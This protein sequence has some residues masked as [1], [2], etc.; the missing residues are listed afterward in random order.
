MKISETDP[1][2]KLVAAMK[3]SFDF[4]ATVLEKVDDS[5][6]GDQFMMFGNRPMSRGRSTGGIGRK[7]DGPLCNGGDLFAAKWDF[8]ADGAAGEEIAGLR[9]R[10]KAGPT[11][12]V[13]A[14]QSRGRHDVSCPYKIT[15]TA[16]LKAA[17][18]KVIPAG[19]RLRARPFRRAPD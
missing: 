17:A 6:L 9:G 10:R 15:K 16:G 8:A 3:D 2:D 14:S 18:T 4:C 19:R 11:R 7:L 5:K 12:Q 1:K 13:Q